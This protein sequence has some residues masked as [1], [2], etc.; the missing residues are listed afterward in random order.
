MFISFITKILAN[1]NYYIG[2]RSVT[3]KFGQKIFGWDESAFSELNHP[4]E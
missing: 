2:Y 1:S 3:V 4:F